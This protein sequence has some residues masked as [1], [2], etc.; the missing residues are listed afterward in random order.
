[1]KKLIL[2]TVLVMATSV[3]Y[4]DQSNVSKAQTFYPQ[5]SQK[6]FKGPA[7]LFTGDVKVDMLFP[8]ND[9]TSFSGAYVTFQ[10]GAR[11]NWHWHPAGQHMIVTDGVALTG[12]RDGKVIEFK[13]GETVWCPSELDHW[14]GATPEAPM[15]HLVISGVKDDKAV[16][17]KEKVTDEQ[18]MK[19]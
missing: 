10:P 7:N 3:A 18:Y 12:T 11:T 17:W 5:G 16:V 19:R 2:I 1:M 13:E 14:H 4:A 8:A 15:T 9:E 6:T